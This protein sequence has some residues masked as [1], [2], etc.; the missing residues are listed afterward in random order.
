MAAVMAFSGMNITADAAASSSVLPSG[1]I[2]LTLA[3]GNKLE[4]LSA[5]TNNT[6]QIESI[7]E[8]VLRDDQMDTTPEASEEESFKNLPRMLPGSCPSDHHGSIRGRIF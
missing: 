4:S 1:G 3:K 8:T 6:K 2:E 5:G 7:I